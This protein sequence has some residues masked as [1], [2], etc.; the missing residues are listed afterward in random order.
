LSPAPPTT[1]FYDDLADVYHLV[2]ADWE[3]SVCRQAEVLDGLLARALGPGPH[4]L[5]DASC[6]IG[7]QALGLAT[8]GHAVAGSDLSPRAVARAR[9]EAAA[10][11]LAIDFSVA[12]LRACDR[13]S[14]GPFDAVLACD[15]SIPHLLTDDE[16]LAAFRAFRR[17]TRPD[18]VALVSVR[19]YAQEDRSTPQLRPYGLRETPEGRYLVF[20]V[21][22]WDP[23]GARYDLAMYFVRDRGGEDAEVLVSRARY[24]AVAVEA[25]AA[26][27]REAGFADVERIDG[28]Y[29]QPVLLAR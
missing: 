12:D 25:L 2:Y 24:Y 15:N 29:F 17:L 20:Q 19:D 13:R 9:R 27:L 5:L 23:D 21:W 14:D 10:R 16:I 7:T 26:L 6:G 1:R 4:R 22:D 8:L 11:G 3:E 18:G 28:V